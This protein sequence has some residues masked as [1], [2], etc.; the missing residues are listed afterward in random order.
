[1]DVGEQLKRHSRRKKRRGIVFL[2]LAVLSAAVILSYML[3]YIPVC[4]I[5]GNHYLPDELIEE[6]LF[7][8]PSEQRFY[9]AVIRD[10]LGR[11]PKIEG[12]KSYTISFLSDHSVSVDV[13]ENEPV[14]AVLLDGQYY[15]FDSTG[16]ILCAEK[17]KTVDAPLVRGLSVSDVRVYGR[18]EPDRPDREAVMKLLSLLAANRIRADEISY[19]A[20]GTVTLACSS[21]QILLGGSRQLEDKVADLADILNSGKLSDLSGILHLEE[22][23]ESSAYIFEQTG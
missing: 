10:R 19:A 14:A 21:L 20:D 23:D 4:R 2:L 12:I 13:S 3:T 7:G 8:R 1:M 6:Q 15:L 22:F 5:S 11:N 9:H 17:E 16:F 18:L